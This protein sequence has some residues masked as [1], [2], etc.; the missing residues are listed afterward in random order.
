MQGMTKQF[1]W[2][3][4][5]RLIFLLSLITI[6]GFFALLIASSLFDFEWSAKII[7]AAGLCG[8]AF[9]MLFASTYLAKKVKCQNCENFAF[10]RTNSDSFEPDVVTPLTMRCVH[11]AQLYK[12]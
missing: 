2:I 3:W 5:I 10:S 6:L 12:G 4:L 7:P 11:C 9:L 1:V 8:V